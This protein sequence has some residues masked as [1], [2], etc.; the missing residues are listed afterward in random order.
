MT[1]LFYIILLFLLTFARANAVTVDC[2]FNEKINSVYANQIICGMDSRVWGGKQFDVCDFE[3]SLPVDYVS[4]LVI[5]NDKGETFRKFSESF[6]NYSIK[7]NGSLPKKGPYGNKMDVLFYNY[8]KQD[9]GKAYW[10]GQ[11][12]FVMK[13]DI[14]YIYTLFVDERTSQSFLEFSASF[15]TDKPKNRLSAWRETMLGFCKVTP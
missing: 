9:E 15:G 12:H 6:I 3:T 10:K 14:N 5:K 2:Q 13:S 4:R 8:H 1:K 7:K 11:H